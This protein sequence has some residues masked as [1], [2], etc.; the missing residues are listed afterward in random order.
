MEEALDFSEQ[1]PAHM[2]WAPAVFFL[3]W[4]SF[5]QWNVKQVFVPVVNEHNCD[6]GGGDGHGVPFWGLFQVLQ[7]GGLGSWARGEKHWCK[8]CKCQLGNHIEYH[9]T[10]PMPTSDVCLHH[11]LPIPLS[12]GSESIFPESSAWFKCA[13]KSSCV[14]NIIPI[15]K[16]MDLEVEMTWGR[17]G[18]VLMV[19]SVALRGGRD[20]HLH[21]SYWAKWHPLPS[22]VTA[23]RLTRCQEEAT[24][25]HS[26]DPRS[27]S[28]INLYSEWCSLGYFIIVTEN[29]TQLNI[30]HQPNPKWFLW[31]IFQIYSHGKL[32]HS[33]KSKGFTV[34]RNN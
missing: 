9:S 3:Q 19:A 28:Q 18:G 20:L 33:W 16:L 8:N 4:S 22:H 31:E 1:A 6:T 5:W 11:L 7:E 34:P 10:R 12:C 21:G 24:L 17:E 23:K 2:L 30:Q 27:V 25:L 32:S 26:Q 15:H 14:R 13:P 29:R